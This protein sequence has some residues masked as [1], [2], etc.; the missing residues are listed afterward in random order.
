[1][2]QLIKKIDTSLLEVPSIMEYLSQFKK[3]KITVEEVNDNDAEILLLGKSEKIKIVFIKNIDFKWWSI[4]RF[5]GNGIKYEQIDV[6][7]YNEIQ[8]KGH[9]RIIKYSGHIEEEND[10]YIMVCSYSYLNNEFVRS[11]KKMRVVPVEE[12]EKIQ[13]C[14]DMNLTELIMMTDDKSNRILKKGYEENNPTL[15]LNLKKHI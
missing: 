12:L 14:E 4:Y 7:F 15:E 3:Y 13:Y 8:T 10:S 1:M 11:W 5:H 2:E 9:N 6:L